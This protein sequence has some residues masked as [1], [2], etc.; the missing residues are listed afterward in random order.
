[1]AAGEARNLSKPGILL[2]LRYI[3]IDTI[4]ALRTTLKEFL[5]S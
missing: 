3:S 5:R 4:L 1:M 2:A